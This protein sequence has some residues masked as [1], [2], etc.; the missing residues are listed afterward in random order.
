MGNP[1][2][3]IVFH[4]SEHQLMKLLLQ[5]CFCITCTRFI[6][7]LEA[8]PGQSSIFLGEVFVHGLI[9][10]DKND[11]LLT[12]EH[13]VVV[14]LNICVTFCSFSELLRLNTSIN[15]FAVI[16]ASPSIQVI[17]LLSCFGDDWM[18][19]TTRNQ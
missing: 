11:V 15:P 6:L 4:T 2:D 12:I 8:S 9:D 16:V 10:D 14:H 13:Q 1:N 19:R 3:G 17:G 18:K 5:L 7:F